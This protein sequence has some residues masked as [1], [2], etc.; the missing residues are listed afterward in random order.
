MKRSTLILSASALD[1]L[2]GDP[3][4]L[5][6]PVRL[7]GSAV[8]RGE[9]L[10]HP[11]TSGSKALAAGTLLTGSIVFAAYVI[12]RTLLVIMPKT[13]RPWLAVLLASTTLAAR[14][15]DDEAR[16]VLAALEAGDLPL[17]RKRVARIVGRDT[18][19]LDQAGICRALIETL[20]ESLSDGFV[21]P[22]FFLALG[23]VPAAM[24]FK[25]VSTMDSMIGHRTPR[26]LYFGR[27]AARLDDVLNF[28]PARLTAAMLLAAKPSATP[29][30][31]RDCSLHPSPNA[32]HPEAAMAGVL[33]V[34]L[35]GPSSYDSEPHDA[36]RINPGQPLPTSA[37][38]RH[39]LMLTRVVAIA[40]TLL[41]ASALALYERRRT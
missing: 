4:S 23:G 3:E 34:Q 37:D 14:N 16:S 19:A 5:P 22:L 40:A 27:P 15:L 20:A 29:V 25:A 33:G 21:A 1:W 18:A 9:S 32:G 30:Y 17:A 26:Y 31:R 7:I 28:I 41:A 36:P 12:P 2:V 35:G 38:A 24:A 8:A 6:H 10:L 11:E 13:L 39:A